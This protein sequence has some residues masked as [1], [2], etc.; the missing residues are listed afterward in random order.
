MIAAG[1]CGQAAKCC[2]EIGL[3]LQIKYS[4]FGCFFFLLFALFL[5]FF[6]WFSGLASFR[7]RTEEIIMY[8]TLT[9]SIFEVILGYVRLYVIF[10][11][12]RG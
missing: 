12:I 1:G 8:F 5:S 3:F 6:L 10:V 11:Q 2:D 9:S 4:V 7:G